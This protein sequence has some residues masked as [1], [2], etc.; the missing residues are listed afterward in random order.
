MSK[1]RRFIAIADNHGDMIDPETEKALFSFVGDFKPEV[2]VHLGD[3]FDFRNLRKGASD[4]EKAA[5]LE[6][7]WE[8]GSDFLRRFFDGGKENHFLRGNHDER[9]YKFS[10]SATGLLRDY[11]NDGI[12]RLESVVKRSRAAMLPYKV[13][14]G[15]LRIGHLKCLHGFAH[16]DNAATK[17]AQAFRNC[18]FGH[19]HTIVSAPVQ[20]DE[21]PM[22]SR[23]IGAICQ[24]EMEY[25]DTKLATLR[26]ENGWAYG[27]LFPDGSY[28]LFQTRKINGSF[29]AAHEI[30]AY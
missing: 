22:E 23:C 25:N 30:R 20:S 9:I 2:R 7:D 3:N 5:S 19:I 18:I 15:I 29:Y 8:M 6:D 1:P 12:K 24:I 16:G 14:K 26:Q 17:H 28:Q 13:T 4:E 11:A 10:N 21:G 27:H